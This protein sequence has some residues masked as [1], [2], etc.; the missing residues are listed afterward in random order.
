VQPTF[1]F[2]NKSAAASHS[3]VNLFDETSLARAHLELERGPINFYLPQH[4]HTP[5][6]K[7]ASVENPPACFLK[8]ETMLSG[9]GVINLR[10]L[11]DDKR[12]VHHRARLLP[13]RRT[14]I[15]SRAAGGCTHSEINCARY[16]A[17]ARAF[18][19]MYWWCFRCVGFK[20]FQLVWVWIGQMTDCLPSNS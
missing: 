6:T 11:R 14:T 7:A 2:G 17:K 4:T 3:Q 15:T 8:N 1:S 18:I 5:R 20:L 12:Q 10:R 13:L 19:I 16:I 9:R